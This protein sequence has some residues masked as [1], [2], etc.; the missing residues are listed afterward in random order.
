M[1]DFEK[2]L[3]CLETQVLTDELKKS[4]IVQALIATHTEY[5]KGYNK[6]CKD[7][8]EYINNYSLKE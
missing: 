6:A 1:D 4:I 7:A 8:V 2:W 5:L 3:E